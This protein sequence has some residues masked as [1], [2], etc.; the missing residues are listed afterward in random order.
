MS[1]FFILIT[2][3]TLILVACSS[4]SSPTDAPIT[5]PETTAIEASDRP[6]PP[7]ESGSSTDIY[8]SGDPESFQILPSE[9]K[10]TYEVGEVFLNQDNRFNVAIGATP[11]VSGEILVDRNNLQNS[12]IGPISVDIS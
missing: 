1:R 6:T 9:S 11:Q 3:F 8:L 5:S 2:R 4:Q 12:T 7:P 10:L